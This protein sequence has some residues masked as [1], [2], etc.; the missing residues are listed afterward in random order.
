V[1]VAENRAIANIFGQMFYGN[2]G[3]LYTNY[4][5]FRSALKSLAEQHP[6]KSV[7][8]PYGIGCVVSLAETGI[9]FMTL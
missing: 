8:L 7:A 6:G 4:E 9:L 1:Q 3:K 2:D 5:A